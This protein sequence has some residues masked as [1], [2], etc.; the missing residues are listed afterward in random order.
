M[1]SETEIDIMPVIHRSLVA[2]ALAL[3]S[4]LLTDCSHS[5]DQQPVTLKYLQDGWVQPVDMPALQAVSKDFARLTGNNLEIIRGVPAEPLQQLAFIRKFLRSGA[6]GPDVVEADVAWLGTLKNDVIDLRPYLSDESSSLSPIIASSYIMDGKVLAL[7]HHNQSGALE[8]RADLLR[9]YGYDHPPNTWAELEKM[10]LRIQSGERAHGNKH[11]WGYIWPGAAEESL[12]C[13]AIEWQVDEGAG[14]IIDDDGNISVNNPPTM[15]AWERARHWIGWISPSSVA[16]YREG[17][18]RG[19][20]ESGRTAFVRTWVGE[21][22]VSMTRQR[23]ELRGISLLGQPSVGEAGFASMPGGSAA[24][25][26]VL[27]GSGLAISKYSTHP[28]K[29]AVL[30]RFILQKEL[31]SFEAQ[32]SHSSSHQSVVYDLST[33]TGRN[34]GSSLAG[35]LQPMIVPRPTRVSG[36]RY[37]QVS[38]AYSS[39]VHSVLTGQKRASDAASELEQDLIRITGLHRGPPLRKTP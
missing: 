26:A 24:R 3:L 20:F 12:T 18:V 23:P 32:K 8:Y 34:S 13:N 33:A 5:F 30:I 35:K 6:G 9:K 36:E 39:A 19:A 1:E 22:G 17:D 21:P 25:V 11:F 28:S 2:S 27:G 29:D 14:P 31:E 10:A 38:R 4:F 16:E 7:P 15:R 37:D